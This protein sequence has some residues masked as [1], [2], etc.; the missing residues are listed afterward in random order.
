MKLALK[1]VKYSIIKCLFSNVG[2]AVKGAINVL[3]LNQLTVQS[4][5]NLTIDNL[6]QLQTNAY[7]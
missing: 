7:A 1:V 4:V 5:S 3:G 6:I 2:L